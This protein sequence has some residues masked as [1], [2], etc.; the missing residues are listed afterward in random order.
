[1]PPEFTRTDA[2]LVVN[3]QSRRGQRLY[4][5]AKEQIG[6]KGINL[7]E[8]HPVRDAS[9]LASVVADVVARGHRF[10]IVGGGDG[11]ISSVVSTFAN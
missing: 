10:V 9:R 2:A 4:A 5:Q 3:T 6:R 11:S 8:S 7:A 1:M